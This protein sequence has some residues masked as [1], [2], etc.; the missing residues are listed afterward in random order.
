[1]SKIIFKN[2]KNIILICFEIKKTFLKI[3]I[4]TLSNILPQ[5]DFTGEGLK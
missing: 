1:M 3:T 5:K 4:A 2:K